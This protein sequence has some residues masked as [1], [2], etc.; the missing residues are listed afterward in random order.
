MEEY[1]YNGL[2]LGYSVDSAA[3]LGVIIALLIAP[4]LFTSVSLYIHT[5]IDLC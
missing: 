2:K 5:A 1:A 4:A 3:R